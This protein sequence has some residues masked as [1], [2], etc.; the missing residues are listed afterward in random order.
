MKC[1]NCGSEIESGLVYCPK[2]GQSIQL[3][4]NYNVLEEEL[5]SKLVEDKD[6]VGKDKFATGVYQPVKISEISNQ[7]DNNSKASAKPSFVIPKYILALIVALCALVFS[8]IVT[9][10]CI[11][12]NKSYDHL[13]E[14]ARK[15]EELASYTNAADYYKLAFEAD[16]TSFEAIFGLGRMYYMAKEYDSS[17][18]ILQQA[19]G[20]QPEN[21]DVY[22]YIIKCYVAMDNKQAI[23]ELYNKA[24]SAE[25]QKLISEYMVSPPELSLEPGDYDEEVVL[26]LTSKENNEI[27]YTTDG[28]DP[29][30]YGSKY[31]T[32]IKFGEGTYVLKAVCVS[33]DGQYSYVVT[34]EYNITIKKVDMPV[35]S[36]VGGNYTYPLVLTISSPSNCTCYYTLDGSEPTI[37]SLVYKDQIVMPFGKSTLKAINVDNEGTVSPVYKGDYDCELAQ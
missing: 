23:Y 13:I 7:E 34:G 12:N 24:P 1:N 29:T 30:K 16:N 15:E 6:A 4:P 37:K 35:V 32:S 2:C 17:L 9:V 26:F 31:R 22:D 20:I 14:N 25:I 18:P 33:D 3:V 36:A 8:I 27:Y 28:K 19:L 21:A 11:N 10:I 5:L